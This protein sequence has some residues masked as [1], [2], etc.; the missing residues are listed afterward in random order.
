M[1]VAAAMTHPN[2]SMV[3][4]RAPLLKFLE[5][6]TGNAPPFKLRQIY[7]SSHPGGDICYTTSHMFPVLDCITYICSVLRSLFIR[8]I[9]I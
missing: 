4:R 2:V 8:T 7:W 6:T 1:G 9:F 3:A 5:I